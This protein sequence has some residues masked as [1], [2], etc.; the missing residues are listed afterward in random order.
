M[1]AITFGPPVFV[2]GPLPVA[3]PRSLLTVPG[4]VQDTLDSRWTNGAALYGYPDGLPDTWDPCLTGTFAVKSDASSFETPDFAAFIAYLP[5]FCSSFSIAQ[6]PDGFAERAELALDATISFAVEKALSR[7]IPMSSNPF[8]ADANADVLAGGAAVNPATGLAYLE[9]AIG[10][11]GRAGLIHA[12]PGVT[13]SWFSTFPLFVP[14]ITSTLFTAN[15]TPVSS[16]GGYK[17]ATPTGE[18]A[19]A[20]GQDWVFATGPVQAWIADEPKLSIEDV[21]DRSN[22]DVTYRAEKYA[23]VTWDT[24]LQAAVLVDWST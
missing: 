2:D 6:D 16:G 15:G 23:L 10:A 19:A 12:T 9:D 3:P 7:G 18:A 20:V 1:S 22:N 8:L 5:I 13:S 24:S 4:V 11:T 14:E 17:G 21:L